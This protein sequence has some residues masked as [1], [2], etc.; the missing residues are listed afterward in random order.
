M[1]DPILLPEIRNIITDVDNKAHPLV[2]KGHLPLAA[3]PISGRRS[4][5]Q[6]F[7]KEFIQS[8]TSRGEVS[9]NLLTTQHGANGVIGVISG[10]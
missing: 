6:A 2:I 1:D 8:S 10:T 5:Q 3:W 4:A 7:Q 9:Q